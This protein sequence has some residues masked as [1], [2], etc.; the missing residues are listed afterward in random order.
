MKNNVVINK[1]SI[2]ITLF[3]IT[4]IITTTTNENDWPM[5]QHDATNTGFS[6]SSFPDS[7]NLSYSLNYSEITND[8]FDSPFSSPVVANG[9]IFIAG[10]GFKTHIFA[11]DENNGSLIW[12]KRLPLTYNMQT[13]N[14]PVVSNSK[15]FVCYGSLFSFPPLSVLFALDENT[16]EIIW[17]KNI[18]WFSSVYS[19]ITF[20]NDK[21]IVGGHL[22]SILPM[23]RLYVFNA[24]NGDLIWQNS[25][26]RKIRKF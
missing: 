23:S 22:T 24:N 14:T 21:I 20:S 11:L 9:K 2:I 10:L 8:S 12:I 5:Y 19:S 18:V 1:V 25:D 4:N 26:W 13:V 15:V 16:G 3:L 17:E 7:L 6:L